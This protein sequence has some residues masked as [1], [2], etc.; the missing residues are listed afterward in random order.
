[1]V[2]Q[3]LADN[4]PADLR[5]IT[6]NDP[7]LK[8]LK[9][10]TV[11]QLTQSVHQLVSELRNGVDQH[12]AQ[13]RF[14]QRHTALMRSA[15]EA[16]HEEGQRDYYGAVSRAPG[17]W[18]QQP[19]DGQTEAQRMAFYAPS[20]AKMA[21][22]AAQAAHQT[23]AQQVIDAVQ[24]QTTTLADVAV[25][26]TG[27]MVAFMLKP[28]EANIL[29]FPGGEPA[30]D[31][32]ITLVFLGDKS[33]L[34]TE[35]IDTL[36]R[37]VQ[38]LAEDEAQPL[39]GRVTGIGRFNPSEHSDGKA[40]IY[41][42]VDVP[43]LHTLQAT[44]AKRLKA[45]G[46]PVH[47]DFAYTPHVTLTYVDADAATPVA[48]APRV[49]LQLDTMTLALGDERIDY[50][51][52][53]EQSNKTLADKSA[54]EV[55]LLAGG[56]GEREDNLAKWQSNIGARIVLQADLTWAGAQDGYVAAGFGDSANPYSS[57][58][59]DLEPTA[60]HCSDCPVVAAGSP[61]DP[62]WVDGGNT[63]PTTP[64]DGNTECGAACKCSL[65]YGGATSST[66]TQDM[67][68]WLPQDMPGL[69]DG[70]MQPVQPPAPTHQPPSPFEPVRPPRGG[71]G[72]MIPGGEFS[73]GQKAALD[74]YRL[75]ELSWNRV[76]GEL[77]ELPNFFTLANPNFTWPRF[78]WETL[79]PAQ[80]HALQ[81]ALEAFARWMANVP[82]EWLDYYD[83]YGFREPADGADV[84]LS[85]PY[86]RQKGGLFGFGGPGHGAHATGVTEHDVTGG[87]TTGHGSMGSGHGG[88]GA[89]RGEAKPKSE[90]PA[91][92]PRAGKPKT[93]KPATEE[94]ATAQGGAKAAKTVGG[95]QHVEQI[96]TK[97]IHVGLNPRE[98]FDQEHINELASSIKENG[99]LQPISVRPHGDGYQIIAGERR[100]RAMKQLGYEHVPAIVHNVNDEQ[101]H[102]LA[103]IENVNRVDMRPSE[104]AKA[105]RALMDRGMSTEEV[106][107]AVGKS[108][109]HVEQHLSLL[110]MAPHLQKAVDEGHIPASV[111]H[112]MSKLSAKGQEDVAERIMRDGL[113]VRSARALIRAKAA[114]ESQ[115][116]M[117]PHVKSITHTQADA[118]ARY[119]DA[120]TR[121]TSAL[122]SLDDET[123]GHYASVVKEP[124][125]ES[126]R[127][128][129]MV[130][131]LRRMQ[132]AL[133]T[134]GHARSLD[135]AQQ[136]SIREF[137]IALYEALGASMVLRLAEDTVQLGDEE[138]T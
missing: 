87:A 3:L 102:R 119:E 99:L 54:D 86:P 27:V 67:K 55:M 71:Y 81:M 45:A 2:A 82:S 98:H 63:L 28:S 72:P 115:M 58:W 22:E 80:Q 91:A 133:E 57:L 18:A 108:P 103:I 59:W 48:Q 83:D 138:N 11:R 116:S 1:M 79:T 35:Q 41:A 19:P 122:H 34:T 131:Q 70:P 21:H 8:R 114:Q 33:E 38:S 13:S 105:Y 117:F 104:T 30:S 14:I 4:A 9:A 24:A 65:R 26:H 5:R 93:E 134:A 37:E 128:D 111:V 69:P 62:P 40:P 84:I 68:S 107:K 109:A 95:G 88:G 44:L 12:T 90:K 52:G 39:T 130:K 20:V 15:Y 46:L 31:L 110:T 7:A 106:A 50:K 92:K 23:R 126:T 127:L 53:D 137:A 129:L 120:I 123:M 74:L 113:G 101:A 132:S 25:K 97:D 66:P 124:F 89:S 47:E 125:K 75:A 6:E 17:K 36:K 10:R 64:G 51:L 100:F 49:R 121:V 77:P 61:Y 135:S 94:K 32:H 76:R 96:A 118:R 42:S 85:N 73:S 56:I 16:A 112:S 29:A 60:S 43:G 136:A 78:E